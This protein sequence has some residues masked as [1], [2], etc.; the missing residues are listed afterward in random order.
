LLTSVPDTGHGNTVCDLVGP[1]GARL[2]ILVITEK[3]QR[4]SHLPGIQAYPGDSV[5]QAGDP[6]LARERAKKTRA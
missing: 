2:R 3:S 5:R 6:H 1:H 4:L